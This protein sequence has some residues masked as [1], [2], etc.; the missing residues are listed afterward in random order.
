MPTFVAHD[1]YPTPFQPSSTIESYKDS[2]GRSEIEESG[3]LNETTFAK[4]P[5]CGDVRVVIK[6][7]SAHQCH[8]VIKKKF[9]TQKPRDIPLLYWILNSYAYP[10]YLPFQRAQHLRLLQNRPFLQPV[11]PM[12]P[13][14]PII[15]PACIPTGYV[16]RYPTEIAERNN[17]PREKRKWRR[18]SYRGE[19]KTRT[20]CV[21]NNKRLPDRKA[22]G[23]EPISSRVTNAAHLNWKITGEIACIS[24]AN[25]NQRVEAVI[26][27]R[28]N[29]SVDVQAVCLFR[30]IDESA[31]SIS[32]AP[33]GG[34]AL[35]ILWWLQ[36]KD[37]SMFLVCRVLVPFTVSCTY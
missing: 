12:P 29:E 4:I 7:Y 13:P 18:Q 5:S 34:G 3:T 22:S 15:C 30:E 1:I 25:E 10:P 9:N 19:K 28:W 20:T 8:S 23:T 35:T 14:V 37:W 26:V 16:R 36:V 31:D 2:V 33:L 32:R 6:I 17:F 27:G 24:T 21:T 11:T